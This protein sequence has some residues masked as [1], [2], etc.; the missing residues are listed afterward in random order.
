MPDI[1]MCMNSSCHLRHSCYRYM[2]EPNPYRQAYAM[3]EPGA[4]GMCDCFARVYEGSRSVRT[5]AQMLTIER[6][7]VGKAATTEGEGGGATGCEP[8]D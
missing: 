1:A 3:F 7:L 4:D 6:G 2:A 8:A 5:V